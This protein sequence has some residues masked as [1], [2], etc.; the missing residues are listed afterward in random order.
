MDLNFQVSSEASNQ[1]LDEKGKIHTMFRAVNFLIKQLLSI[2]C[3]QLMHREIKTRE[4][5]FSMY[6]V[7]QNQC[8]LYLQ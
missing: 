1:L 3:R 4:V 7:S 5:L 2:L 8:R 6:S